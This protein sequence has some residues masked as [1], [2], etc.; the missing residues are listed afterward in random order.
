[1]K[2][3]KIV[4]KYILLLF[5]MSVFL[6]MLT[7]SIPEDPVNMLLQQYQIPPTEQNIQILREQWGLNETYTVQYMKWMT[8][9][10]RGDWGVS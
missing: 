1:M 5:F 2:Y 10:L 8:A 9:F 7:R 6:F 4:F 3:F